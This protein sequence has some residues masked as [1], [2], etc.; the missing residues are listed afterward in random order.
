MAELV[1]KLQPSLHASQGLLV[2]LQHF[3]HSRFIE[4]HLVGSQGGSHA[5]RA[6][7]QGTTTAAAAAAGSAAPTSLLRAGPLGWLLIWRR[8]RLSFLLRSHGRLDRASRQAGKS[9]EFLE[10][11][12]C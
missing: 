5:I 9:Y 10:D 2:K 8:C 11:F 12:A 1:R 6:P 3:Q 7:C 4:P